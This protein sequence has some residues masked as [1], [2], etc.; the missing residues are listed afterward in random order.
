MSNKVLVMIVTYNRSKYLEKL[1]N[2]LKFQ[3][4]KLYGVLIVDNNSSDGTSDMLKEMNI[5]KED[6]FNKLY[7]NELD[8]TKYYY[9]RNSENEG[10]S[11]GFYMAFKLAGTL[12]VDYFWVMDDD[13]L[14][15]NN[16]L[17]NL[18]ANMSDKVKVCIPNRSDAEFTD[19]AIVGFDLQNPFKIKSGKKT[20][21]EIK[22]QKYIPVVDM[23]FEGPLM[24]KEIVE[25]VGLPNK[26]YFIF[27]DD[28]DYA[29]RCLEY[30]EI[31]LIPSAVLH[32]QIIPR[33]NKSEHMNWRNYYDIRNSIVFDRKYGKNI[34]VKKVR[35]IY[36]WL[37]LT[38]RAIFRGKYYNFK[39]INKGYK[40]G[41]NGLLGKRVNPGEL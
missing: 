9:Y 5:V 11:G 35:P 40:D 2:N 25:K 1:L 30:S 32:K 17:E 18:L 4:Q 20:Y 8:G 14:P 36:L 27:Y 16:C 29:K 24:K 13:V 10:G 28:T 38:L 31:Y 22:D 19:K 6:S 39:I 12:P 7:E 21:V 3:T 15:D 34:L 37:D 26:E 41:I 23:P 33:R